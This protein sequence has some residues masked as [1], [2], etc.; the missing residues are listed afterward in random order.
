MVAGKFHG[1]IQRLALVVDPFLGN[2]LLTSLTG[3]HVIPGTPRA[4]FQVKSGLLCVQAWHLGCCFEYRSFLH[5]VFLRM[6]SPWPWK[7]LKV[8]FS[9]GCQ[10]KD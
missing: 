5:T 8:S 9:L 1:C 7:Y 2:L 6:V 10:E 3:L 4:G